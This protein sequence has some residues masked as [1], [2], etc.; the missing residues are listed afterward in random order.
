MR[1]TRRACRTRFE[2]RGPIGTKSKHHYI[3]M[4]SSQNS[5]MTVNSP[6]SL[7]IS[8]TTTQLNSDLYASSNTFLMALHF[9]PS[10]NP[11][12]FSGV[13]ILTK[14]KL[15]SLASDA[16]SAVL[17]HPESPERERERDDDHVFKGCPYK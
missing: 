7:S 3:I 14:G 13:M 12:I 2:K 5:H 11:I 1:R 8:S 16:A 6:K 10:E 17:P 4:T 9:A 15:E